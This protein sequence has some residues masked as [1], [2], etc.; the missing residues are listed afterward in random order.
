M[1]KLKV[2]LLVTVIASIILAIFSDINV[3]WL[4]TDFLLTG[5][6]PFLNYSIGFATSLVFIAIVIFMG[7]KL[8]YD[9]K[10]ELYDSSIQT[11][12]RNIVSANK[13]EEKLSIVEAL[14]DEDET[15]R[16][17]LVSEEELDEAIA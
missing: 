13:F 17:T 9:A 10:V 3:L 6:I 15:A 16:T 7:S 5:K 8:I 4:V 12:K 1:K 11:N 14:K 2:Y